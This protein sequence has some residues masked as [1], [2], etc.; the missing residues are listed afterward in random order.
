MNCALK[1]TMITRFLLAAAASALGA[2]VGLYFSKRLKQKAN[3]Y[4]ALI[5]FI[6]H[7]LT[8]IKF[9]KDP[10]KKIMH[11]FVSF[12][13][14]PLNKNLQEYIEAAAP[15]NL[16]LSRGILK[17]AEL[18]EVKQFLLSLGTL[19]S[20]TQIFEL[21]AYKEKFASTKTHF[22]DKRKTYSSMYVKLGFLA[23]L[24]VGIIII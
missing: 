22:G 9:R 13:D 23:G 15:E 17:K 18:A 11:D 16:H 10:I 5:D 20:T 2:M 6:N 3:Y 19:D 14:T 7:T 24:A 21:E 1:K 12:A 4:G 8:Q